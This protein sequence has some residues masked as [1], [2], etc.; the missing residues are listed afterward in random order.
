MKRRK[1]ELLRDVIYRF[2][3]D[4]GLETPLNEHRAIEAWPQVAGPMVARL[5][6]RVDLRS[7]TLYIKI[8]RP[9][10]RSDLMMGR[11]QLTQRINQ[12]V[13]AQVVQQIVFY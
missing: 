7:G 2:L 12:A 1:S 13:G 11:T 3:R 4:E 9:A 10:L 5:T 6:E 8:S